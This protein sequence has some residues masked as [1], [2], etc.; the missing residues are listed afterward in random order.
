MQV[1]RTRAALV[2]F[3]DGASLNANVTITYTGLKIKGGLGNDFIEN[4][5]KNGIVTDGNG[6]DD[7]VLGGAG[8]KAALGT[9]TGDRVASGLATW[10]PMRQPVPP[11]AIR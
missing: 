6:H 11:S 1:P 8:A 2:T 9:G 7:V 4:D 3:D 5:A 10:G